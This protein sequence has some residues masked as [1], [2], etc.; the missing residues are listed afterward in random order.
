M[1]PAEAQDNITKERMGAETAEAAVLRITQEAAHS[2]GEA[3]EDSAEMVL[4]AD[5]VP[6][7]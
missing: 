1:G 7:S 4:M 2:L 6:A 5:P 3:E